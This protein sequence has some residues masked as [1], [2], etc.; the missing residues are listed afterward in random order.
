MQ[1]GPSHMLTWIY[2]SEKLSL[3]EGSQTVQSVG[4][5]KIWIY[6]IYGLRK[7]RDRKNPNG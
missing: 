6:F 3:K 7:R 2:I 1:R 4:S 5:I